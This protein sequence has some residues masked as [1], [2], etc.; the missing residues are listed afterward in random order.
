M[1]VS[2]RIFDLP[3]AGLAMLAGR[4]LEDCVRASEGRTMV[5]EVF[6]AAPGLIDGVHNAELMASHGADIIV[7]NLV[8]GAWSPPSTWSFP[9]L[10]RM[11]D[12]RELA[13]TIGRPVGVNL[14]P[15]PRGDRIPPQRRA[16]A[17][18][19]VELR[20]AGTALFVLTANPG[21]GA[22]YADLVDVTK[23]LRDAVG[24]DAA[25]WVGKMHHAGRPERLT[26]EALLDLVDAGASGVLVP[27]PGT[28]PG[29]TRELATAATEAVHER[30]VIVLGTIGTSQEGAPEALAHTL[31]LVAKEIGVDAHHVGDAGYH[32]VGDPHLLHAYSLAV[33]GRRHTWRRMALGSRTPQRDLL[34]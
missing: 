15:D 31:A 23:D 7:L 27:I 24:A 6:A 2:P 12:L 16:T 10:G 34:D 29:V 28:V 3:R 32:G 13:A 19:A 14:E 21:T 4:A 18:N 17:E 30:G 11:A 22:S 8:E 33:R 26:P 1:A 20:D 9:S 25:I 5:S